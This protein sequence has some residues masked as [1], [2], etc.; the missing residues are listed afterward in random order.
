MSY[1]PYIIKIT[2]SAQAKEGKHYIQNLVAGSVSDGSITSKHELNYDSK[3]HAIIGDVIFD[4]RLRAV[5]YATYVSNGSVGIP[6]GAKPGTD[7]SVC[8]GFYPAFAYFKEY[9]NELLSSLDV[10]I[11][12]RVK[13]LYYNGLYI[14]AFSVLELFL[15]D[16]LMCG[17]FWKEEYYTRA[18]IKLGVKERADQFVVEEKLRNAVYSKVFHRFDEVDEIFR[19]VFGF[20]FPDWTELDEKIEE[21]H[22]IIHRFALSKQDRMVVCDASHEDV[23]KLIQIICRFVEKMKTLC[24]LSEREIEALG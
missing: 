17:V 22:N 20:G 4:K 11:D 18:L 10:P 5:P 23:E 19:S 2:G 21:R 16:L 13:D 1:R 7:F 12:E 24:G 14:S 8:P 15:S 9:I 6:E 3:K